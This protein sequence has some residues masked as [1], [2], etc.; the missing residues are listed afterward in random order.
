MGALMRSLDWSSTPLGPPEAWPQSLRTTVSTC[1]NS[2]FPILVWWGRDLVKLYNDAYRPILGNKHPSSLGARGRDVWPEI[3]DI[4]GPMLAGVLERGEATWSENQYLPMSRHGFVEETYF[5]FSYSPIRGEQGAIDGVY[6]AVTETTRQVIGDRRLRTL[7]DLASRA[8]NAATIDE[9]L[10][11]AATVL[12][13]NPNDLPTVRIQLGSAEARGGDLA[14]VAGGI[15]L[16]VTPS[17]RLVLD[18]EYRG[19]LSL[20]AGQI[21]AAVERVR[22]LQ[23]ARERAEALAAIDRAKTQFFS[24]VSHEFRTPLTLMLGPIEDALARH[25]P[26]AGEDLATAHRNAQRLL[27][28]VNTLLDFS[29]AEAGRAQ[30]RFEPVDLAATTAEIASGFRSAVETA[31]LR[32]DVECDPLGEAVFVDR[33]LWEKVVLNLLSNAFKFTFGG[34]IG[35]RVRRE[36]ARAVVEV[37]DTGTG[38][39][40]DQL[41]RVFER[42]H[43]VEGARARNHEGSGIG[44]SLVQE[45]VKLHGGELSVTSELG[46][47]TTFAIR[48]PFGSAHVPAEQ[49]G[50]RET[51]PSAAA[52]YV[53]EAMRWTPVIDQAPAT[54]RSCVLVCDDNADMREYLARILGDHCDVVQAG[55][56]VEA[57]DLARERRVDLV[58]ADVMMPRLDGFGLLRELRRDDRL[59]GTPLIMLSA[60]AGEEARADGIEA[61]ADDYLVKPFST[62]ELLARVRNQLALRSL[63]ERLATQRAALATLFEH[64]PLPIA[65]MRGDQLVYELAN[66]AYRDIVRR[67]VLGKPFREALPELEGQGFD[68][69]LLG[70][71]SS[72]KPHVGRETLV[73]LER[74]GKLRDVYFTFVYAPIRDELGDGVV[75]ICMDVTDQVRA[76]NELENLA[77]DAKAANRAKDEFLAMLGHELRNPLAPMVTALE[78]MR[79]RG[80]ESTREEQVLSRQVGHLS[81]L[82]DDL[83]DVSRITK[84]RID[85][86]RRRLELYDVV[87]RGLEVASPLFEQRQNHVVVDVARH[88]LAIEGDPD[89]LA[90][91][92]G[93]LLTNAAKYSDPR[94]RI[95]VIATRGADTV[96]LTVKDQGV[97]IAPEMLDSVFGLFVQQRQTLARSQG[98]LGLG[99]A[100]ARSLVELHGG[101]ITAYSDGVGHGSEFL[102]E[103]PSADSMQPG[104]RRAI[105]TSAK[106]VLIV[107]DNADALAMLRLVLEELGCS[108]ETA[109]DGPSALDKARTFHPEIALLDIGLPV[110]DGYELA[111]RLREH[112]SVHLVAVTGYGQESDRKRAM[113]AGFDHHL[114][115]P[116]DVTKLESIVRAL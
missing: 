2:R 86:R 50:T 10:A 116:V 69:L 71:M 21:A 32:F 55:D 90:Q 85:L 101:T 78:L 109:I 67:D 48:L 108:V 52:A 93:N 36:G 14:F 56:G 83:L 82:V 23:E 111:R 72:G 63:K 62:R 29:R 100:I 114:V 105:Q 95:T 20:I 28:L 40:A 27:K 44:L 43:R 38:I 77:N 37:T 107:D 15:T 64:T 47:G 34:A 115:K 16:C 19:F 68:E 54:G 91:V 26:L 5:T 35:V 57:L 103:L 96:R 87:A 81:R 39:A 59:R 104:V 99:L 89:R 3:W 79:M 97:G 94:T 110:M 9:V 1:L 22:M 112:E 58:I 45:L 92:V 51:A 65:I 30:A 76:R 18:D 106:R 41:P 60:R 25:Q 84:G 6:C 53:A 7:R 17:P 46:H 75:V 11:V 80:A 98:G 70:V 113:A 13:E 49:L 74:D 12:A 66:D 61:G 102:I 73:K 8:A 4:I 42:F 24:N 31:G 33:S 88:G